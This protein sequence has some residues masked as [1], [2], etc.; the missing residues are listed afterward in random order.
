MLAEMYRVRY[1]R[2]AGASMKVPHDADGEAMVLSGTSASHAAQ[3]DSPASPRTPATLEPP[4]RVQPSA[5]TNP[6]VQPMGL[7]LPPMPPDDEEPQ[8]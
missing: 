6:P 7:P 8:P 2:D 4:P 5:P 3:P 1:Q